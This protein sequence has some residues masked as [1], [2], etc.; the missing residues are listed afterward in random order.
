MKKFVL[1]MLTPERRFFLGEADSVV[2]KAVDGETEILADHVP[3]V[4]AL[5]PDMVRIRKDGE[6]LFCANGE[7]FVTVDKDK[8]FILCQT[9]EWP[10]EI[11][12][13]RVNRAIRE[14][15]EKMREATDTADYRVSKMTI[16]RAMA[17]LKVKEL[18]DN[19][20]K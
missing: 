20:K 13:E 16:A 3:V 10:E 18:K 8:V 19:Q 4:I 6:T 7:G 12:Y 5:V 14:H 15:T 2:V 1:E 17:R 9:F 11:E